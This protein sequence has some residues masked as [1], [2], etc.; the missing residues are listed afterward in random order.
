MPG[1]GRISGRGT[2]AEE[3]NAARF[4]LTDHMRRHPPEECL[5]PNHS[6][7]IWG[8]IGVVGG[9]RPTIVLVAKARILVVDDDPTVVEVLTRYL[10]R[11]GFEVRSAADGIAALE[12]ATQDPPDLIVLDLMLPEMH[13]LDV[14][15]RVRLM[16]R[17][18]VIMLTALGEE[19]DRV[20]G[21]E[22]GADDYVTKPFSP[23]EVTAR[24]KSVLN[25]TAADVAPC[26]TTGPTLRAGELSVD[27]GA[28]RVT[29]AGRQI[30]LTPRELDLLV[31]LMRNPGVVFRRQE[32]FEAVWGWTYGDNATITVHIRRLRE[33]L[34]PDPSNPVRILTVW[35]VGYQFAA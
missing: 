5:R 31:L 34:E 8:A 35:G 29:L 4:T 17:V 24:V 28:R 25:R 16:G 9:G 14:F 1:S 32:L 6:L 2:G 27:V 7:K 23:R 13:G 26:L 21:L 33:K 18:P 30:V 15:R 3:S 22:V 11:E 12:A 20:G 19:E 10:D